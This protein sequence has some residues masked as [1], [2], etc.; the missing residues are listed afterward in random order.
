MTKAYAL[1]SALANGALSYLGV[2][3]AFGLGVWLFDDPVTQTAIMGMM[4]MAA[5]GLAATALRNNRPA[6]E[7]SQGLP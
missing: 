5:A 3:F 4:L 1:G 7:N 2:A 6:P